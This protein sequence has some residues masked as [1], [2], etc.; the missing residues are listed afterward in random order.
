MIGTTK[1]DNQRKEL[2]TA[3]SLQPTKKK[4]TKGK[5]VTKL[6]TTARV[7]DEMEE[8]EKKTEKE[9][10]EQAKATG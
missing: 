7:A 8:V 1:K 4:S 6:V 9:R 2:Q 5:P 10:R 3:S